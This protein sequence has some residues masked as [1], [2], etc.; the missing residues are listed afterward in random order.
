MTLPLRRK[1]PITRSSTATARSAKALLA[2]LAIAVSFASADAQASNNAAQPS[3]L[4][5]RAGGASAPAAAPK[6]KPAAARPT[7]LKT[8]AHAPRLQPTPAPMPPM[9]EEEIEQVGYEEE[10]YV[11]D[12]YVVEEGAEYEL[13]AQGETVPSTNGGRT[14]DEL[15]C[16]IENLRTITEL[17]DATQAAAGRFP[18]ECPAP[19][20]RH[21]EPR[22]WPETTFMWKASALCHKPLY[23]EDVQLERYGHSWGPVVQPVI[24][25]AEFFATVPILPYKMGVEL[26]WECVYPL[27]YYRPGDCAPYMIPPV[28]VSV[29]GAVFQGAATVGGILL[30]P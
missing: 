9:F 28:P 10:Q 23:F 5:I 19:H 12:E 2:S 14:D 26:P 15:D 3:M 29:R 27:G 1:R 4:K 17:T 13:V 7:K 22:D 18:A 24:S 8:L 16:D 20:S 6:A 21:F 30:I 11:S 25:G